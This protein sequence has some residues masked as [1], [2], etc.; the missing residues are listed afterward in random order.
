MVFNGD[1][2]ITRKLCEL[3]PFLDPALRTVRA[4]RFTVQEL[5]DELLNAKTNNGKPLFQEYIAYVPSKLVGMETWK[6][7]KFLK[8]TLYYFCERWLEKDPYASVEKFKASIRM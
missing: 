7:I 8:N 4:R 6:E 2:P 3:F 1:N 5:H